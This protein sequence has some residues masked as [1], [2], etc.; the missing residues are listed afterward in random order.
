MARVLAKGKTAS[1]LCAMKCTDAL[2]R[3]KQSAEDHSRAVQ[4]EWS[5]ECTVTNILTRGY[6]GRLNL[7]VSV[8]KPPS[9]SKRLQVL[10]RPPRA[11]RPLSAASWL[12]VKRTGE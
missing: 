6:P 10:K 1:G 3:A 2:G 7:A 8:T 11:L 4:P 5:V 9:I 12:Q